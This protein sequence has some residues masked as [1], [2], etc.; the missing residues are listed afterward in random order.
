M[1]ARIIDRL[2]SYSD[3]LAQS[4][5]RLAQ[6]ALYCVNKYP[7]VG[8][9]LGH[10]RETLLR[11]E[12]MIDAPIGIV[13]TSADAK[14]IL[15]SNELYA[16]MHGYTID[17]LNNIPLIN[18]FA[19]EVHHTLPGH[20]RDVEERG[21]STFESVHMRK[22]G[23]RFTAQITAKIIRNKNGDVLRRVV[24][25]KDITN[26]KNTQS[27][28]EQI[29]ENSPIPTELYDEFGVLEIDNPAV[30]K[31]F[32]R[33]GVNA[34]SDDTN[35]GLTL[36]NN[37][38]ITTQ[39][40]GKLKQGIRVHY[41]DYFDPTSFKEYG[42]Y[43]SE[44]VDPMWLDIHI[45]P[46]KDDENKPR[47]YLLH[48]QDIT[49][50]KLEEEEKN[51]QLYKDSLTDLHN[52]RYFQKQVEILSKGRR[53]EILV[54]SI[55]LDGLKIVNDTY[56]H[57]AGD[58]YIKSAAEILKEIFRPQDT[59]A[60]TGGD[61]IIVLMALDGK[62]IDPNQI[63]DR[64]KE[65][66]RAYN[67]RPDCGN[68]VSLSIGYAIAKQK[69]NLGKTINAADDAMYEDKHTKTSHRK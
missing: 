18:L 13:A 10:D 27:A 6:L 8:N 20:F 1:N 25:L 35:I 9:A 30:R 46:I 52:R 40:K 22:D 62:N 61:E 19:P 50:Q 38:N 12:A 64:I 47:K 63:I 11:A 67:D 5:R 33:E 21:I 31:L 32:G 57:E 14:T 24:Y 41:Q 54:I 23:S 60:R 2:Q 7:V 39:N 51:R 68:K 16:S 53:D 58:E 3:Q 69:D 45:I 4:Q 17:E 65:R 43:E 66:V 34:S 26:E 42:L 49:R 36:F 28:L 55:D 29:I 15:L 59:I 48:V 37:P 56:G 44:K